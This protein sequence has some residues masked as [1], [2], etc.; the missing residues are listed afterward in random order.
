M[1]LERP[2]E[3]NRYRFVIIRRL[4]GAYLIARLSDI[5][6]QLTAVEFCTTT[7]SLHK[8]R[9]PLV[10]QVCRTSDH[11]THFS[12]NFTSHAGQRRELPKCFSAQLTD[13]VTLAEALKTSEWTRERTAEDVWSSKVRM[14]AHTRSN[15]TYAST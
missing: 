4:Q 5:M 8:V 13:V 15:Q 9:G 12:V 2:R 10:L 1:D 6:I 14:N 7:S 3:P 11:G